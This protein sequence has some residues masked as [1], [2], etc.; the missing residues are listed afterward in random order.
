MYCQK[1][2]TNMGTNEIC[3]GCGNEQRMPYVEKAERREIQ[4]RMKKVAEIGGVIVEIALENALDT[5]IRAAGLKVQKKVNKRTI[6]MT[7]KALVKMKLEKKTLR[8]RM[9]NGWKRKR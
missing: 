6:E 1:C 8:D 2:G 7:H 4:G 3:L 5:S 9:N